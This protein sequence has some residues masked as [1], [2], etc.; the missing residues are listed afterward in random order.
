MISLK[1]FVTHVPY[2]KSDIMFDTCAYIGIQGGHK[3]TEALRIFNIWVARGQSL[4]K[5]YGR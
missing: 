1:T 4:S 3:A 5:E 2:T